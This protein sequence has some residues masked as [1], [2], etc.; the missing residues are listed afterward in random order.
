MLNQF[1][2]NVFYTKNWRKKQKECIFC[3]FV[4]LIVNKNSI[5]FYWNSLFDPW[6]EFNCDVY[7]AVQDKQVIVSFKFNARIK[8]FDFMRLNMYNMRQKTKKKIIFLHAKFHPTYVGVFLYWQTAAAYTHRPAAAFVFIGTLW[9]T[10]FLGCIRCPSNAFKRTLS[11]S[12]YSP[13]QFIAEYTLEK[14]ERS[15]FECV[16]AAWHAILLLYE[17]NWNFFRN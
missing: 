11:V 2:I 7:L 5:W 16:I 10:I 12:F 1:R 8:L 9:Q 14:G 3:E 6:I 4:R 17:L 13:F 15:A